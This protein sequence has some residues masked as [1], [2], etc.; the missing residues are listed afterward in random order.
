MGKK[1]YRWL[2]YLMIVAFLFTACGKE[3]VVATVNGEKITEKQFNAR[4][5][6][7]SS[8]PAGFPGAAVFC[9]KLPR[10]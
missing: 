8:L 9:S 7:E 3:N 10:W 5:L 1:R 6:N 2:A 4:F